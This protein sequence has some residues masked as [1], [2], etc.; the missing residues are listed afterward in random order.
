MQSL[1]SHPGEGLSFLPGA[2]WI[3]GSC[4]VLLSMQGCTQSPASVT[5]QGASFDS[6][7]AWKD[8]ETLVA[9]G[10]RQA[11]T[12]GA[13]K[14]RDYLKQELVGAGLKPVEETFRQST[15]G[16]ELAFSNVYVDLPP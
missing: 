6:A 5:T 16:G 1:E 12:P 13:E 11:G 15:P 14:T 8:L 2:S 4:F 10:P 7:R 9:I 3:A